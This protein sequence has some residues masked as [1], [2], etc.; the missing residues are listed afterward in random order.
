M[1]RRLA[2]GSSRRLPTHRQ[3]RRSRSH[4]ASREKRCRVNRPNRRL[5]KS[6]GGENRPTFASGRAES[7]A[8]PVS[9][10]GQV[11]TPRREAAVVRARLVAKPSGQEKARASDC[12]EHHQRFGAARLVTCAGAK[13]SARDA[14][15]TE[16][17][18]WS[19]GGRAPPDSGER[20]KLVAN[21]P[22]PRASFLPAA[23]WETG[24][25]SVYSKGGRGEA[26]LEA[27]VTRSRRSS[28]VPRLRRRRSTQAPRRAR[29]RR[30]PSPSSP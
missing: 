28:A 10:A 13:S 20:R 3:V 16:I 15:S 11:K 25:P 2:A 18:G 24:P 22:L 23:T 8:Y 6:R 12:A 30:P 21:S 19:R 9:R 29:S 4:P 5:V 27:S 1:E 17:R 7:R 26:S 14:E